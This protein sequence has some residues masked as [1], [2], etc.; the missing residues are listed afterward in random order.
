M[1]SLVSR[2]QATLAHAREAGLLGETKNARI[3]GRVSSALIEAAKRRSGAISN[4]EVIELALATLAIE[5]DF[6][7]A[8]VRRKG[9]LPRDVDLEF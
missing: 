5:D 6:G 8:L 2:H 7:D 4:T 9:S 1:T 3:A